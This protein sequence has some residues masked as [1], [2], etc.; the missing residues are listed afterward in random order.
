MALFRR[1]S[2]RA[3]E[4]PELSEVVDETGEASDTSPEATAPEEAAIGFD[5]SNGPY[6][7]SEAPETDV[8]KL[9]L[10]SLVITGFPGMEIRL[11]VDEGSGGV[12]SATA[13]DGD[14]AVQLQ[15][16]AAPRSAG[17]WDE[18]RAELLQGIRAAGGVADE[19]EGTF[20][21][22]LDAKVPVDAQGGGR[23][24]SPTRFVGV[25]GPRWFLRGVFNA[26]SAAD[27]EKL[28]GV[29]R[30]CV[31][32]RGEAPMAPKGLLPL[33][34]PDPNAAS[35][36]LRPGPLRPPERGPEITETR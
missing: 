31:I 15:A 7:A 28:E 36:A 32:V 30:N 29:F 4:E 6:D 26:A 5:R 20:G 18:V 17:V 2:G 24:L 14:S 9:D 12:V 10:G 3:A 35:G 8:A 27:P 23:T 25:D 22:E 34:L 21:R 19:V 16:F 11:E 33:R 13:I 1:R